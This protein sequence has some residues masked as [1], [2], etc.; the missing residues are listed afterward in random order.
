MNLTNK[1]IKK[2]AFSALIIGV[3]VALLFLGNGGG[4]ASSENTTASSLGS[5]SG[6][7]EVFDFGTISMKD[8]VVS[9]VFELQN[10]GDTPIIIGKVYTSCMCTTATLTDESGEKYGVFGMP[11]HGLLS[12]TNVLVVPGETLAVEARFDSAAHGLSG[13]GLNERSIYLETNSDTS[14]KT[15]LRFRAT[16]MR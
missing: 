15:E 1:I 2:Y 5:F 4:V 12:E 13:V 3:L 11:G 7:Q 10:N 14:P 16:V 6:Q 9:H 8:G